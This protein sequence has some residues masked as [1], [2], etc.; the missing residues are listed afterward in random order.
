MSIL[1]P[2]SDTPLRV[3]Q[4]TRRESAKGNDPV[5]RATAILSLLGLGA[6][7]F[8]QIVATLES[9]P[10]L[11]VA[12]LLLIAAFLAVATR[13][14][15]SG[16]DRLTWAASAVVSVAAIGGYSFTRLLSTPLDN[17]DVGNWACM[18][19]LAALFV[20]TLPLALS[21]YVAVE[22]RA[23]P[24]AKSSAQLAA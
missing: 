2:I 21:I 15:F 17:Q 18:L 1:R 12:Y 16:G 20:E 8:L 3:R 11:G 6:I 24:R 5:L 13:L 23:L 9:T 4:L 14:C 7:H 22:K 10:L 19:G